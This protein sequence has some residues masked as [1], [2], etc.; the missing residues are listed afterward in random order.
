MYSLPP[1]FGVSRHS[2][3][4][5]LHYV[6]TYLFV[7]PLMTKQH[8]DDILIGRFTDVKYALTL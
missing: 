3:W 1:T 6:I 5:P 2:S 8:N 7:N 4:K